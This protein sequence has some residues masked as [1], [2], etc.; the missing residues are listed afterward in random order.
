M[1]ENIETE[2]RENAF[3]EL[4]AI[5]AFLLSLKSNTLVAF[6]ETRWLRRKGSKGNRC[7]GATL[8]GNS[9]AFNGRQR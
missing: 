4:F 2:V 8:V 7:E 6:I 5:F 3:N 1:V 9:P